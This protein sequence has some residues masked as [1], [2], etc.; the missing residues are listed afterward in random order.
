MT[1]D[2]LQDDE[3]L[4]GCIQ[5]LLGPQLAVLVARTCGWLGV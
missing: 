3:L 4:V 5:M 2:E 1:Q